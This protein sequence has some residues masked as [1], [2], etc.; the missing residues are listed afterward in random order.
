MNE[1]KSFSGVL[2]ILQDSVQKNPE[3]AALQGVDGPIQK[4]IPEM[5]K[6]RS[7]LQLKKSLGWWR[8]LKWPF[9][10]KETLGFISQIE[11]LKGLILVALSTGLL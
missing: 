3:L 2:T 11:K 1:L 4:C 5:I 7:K 6:L 8:K 10:E 9:E